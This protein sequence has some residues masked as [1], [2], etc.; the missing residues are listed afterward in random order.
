MTSTLPTVPSARPYGTREIQERIPLMRPLLPLQTV[1][2]ILDRRADE[3]LELIEAG[4]LAWAFDIAAAPG[5]GRREIR[6]WRGS[7]LDYLRGYALGDADQ[8]QV[9]DSILPHHRPEIRG[10]ELERTLSCSGVH[11][12]CLAR[13]RALHVVCQAGRGPNGFLRISRA[14]V[15]DFLADRR[16]Q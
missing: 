5:S 2:C 7:V 13:S 14:S 8:D 11:I 15:V 9:L 10:P 12:A 1:E 4:R 16:L 3:L 6:V